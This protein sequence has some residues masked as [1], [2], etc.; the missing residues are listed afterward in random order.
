MDESSKLRVRSM[1]AAWLPVLVVVAVVLA[2][3]GGWVTYT[4][5]V[6]PGTATE[7]RTTTVWTADSEFDHSATVTRENPIHAIGTVL[8]DRSAYLQ[9]AAPVLDGAVTV[10]Q[11]GLSENVTVALD[12]TLVLASAD[13]ETT[14]WT[15]R[16]SLNDT[17]VANA[18]GPVTLTFA[19]N[20][21]RV[22]ERIS[23]IESAVGATPGTTNTSVV[24]DATVSGTTADGEQRRLTFSRRV[25]LSVEGDTYAVN[26]PDSG[27][28]R[29]ERTTTVTSDREYGPVYAVGG[30]LALLLGVAAVGALGVTHREGRI[31]L[32]DAERERLDYLDD[33]AEYDEW[34]VSVSLP[35]VDDQRRVATASSLADLV[36][37]AIDEGTAVIEAPTGGTFHVVTDEY[38]YTYDPPAPGKQDDVLAWD[39][40]SPE[41]TEGASVDATG[42]DDSEAPRD[43]P[44]TEAENGDWEE[45]DSLDANGTPPTEDDER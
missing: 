40:D 36:N 41:R 15:D 8:T 21:S 19:L 7:Q 43:G 39:D 11:Q 32:S 20:T 34:I 28:E 35:P 12:A 1:L 31:G 22:T 26:A 25:S 30:P 18:D 16:R 42:D 27:E 44:A 23:E 24:V 6:D 38:R 37:L 45:P 33:R 2:G 13:E 4:A 17:R 5:H 14:Y 29:V 3:V 10:E 9:S